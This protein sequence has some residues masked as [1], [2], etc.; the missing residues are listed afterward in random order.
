MGAI[1][2]II[3]RRT[4]IVFSYHGFILTYFSLFEMN[5]LVQLHQGDVVRSGVRVVAVLA[6][7]LLPVRHFALYLHLPLIF[8]KIAIFR[9]LT[10]NP[11]GMYVQSGRPILLSVV[12]F[13]V[14]GPQEHL[15]LLLQVRYLDIGL[16]ALKTQILHVKESPPLAHLHS[17]RSSPLS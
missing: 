4:H 10:S 1:C 9:Y 14:S 2:R 13:K 12:A 7:L 8:L 3:F 11:F 17:S 16:A 5:E 6:L 15:D